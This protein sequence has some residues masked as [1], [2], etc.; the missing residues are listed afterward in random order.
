MLFRIYEVMIDEPTAI[1][2]GDVSNIVRTQ[3]LVVLR[4]Y[5][6]SPTCMAG[7]GGMSWTE[8]TETLPKTCFCDVGSVCPLQCILD[9]GGRCMSQMCGECHVM[10]S[11]SG[12]A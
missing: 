3:F 2:V 9:V 1:H 10:G 8:F 6:P 7:L 11:A 12:R 5:A 4:K